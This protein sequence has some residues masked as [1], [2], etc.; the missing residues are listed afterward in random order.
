MNK[1]V[2]FKGIATV[3]GV[4]VAI[5][6]NMHDKATLSQETKQEM[7]N[8]CGANNNCIR[9]LNSSFDSCFKSSIDFDTLDGGKLANCV[10]EY[11]GEDFFAYEYY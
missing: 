1:R 6:T 8:I 3:V 5:G 4:A 2:M 7:L 10:N 9:A 11:A